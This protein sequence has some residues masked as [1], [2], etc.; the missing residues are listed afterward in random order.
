MKSKY[1]STPVHISISNTIPGS[2]L[3]K[4][5]QEKVALSCRFKVSIIYSASYFNGKSSYYS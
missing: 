5:T 2:I 3:Q 1:S 4:V